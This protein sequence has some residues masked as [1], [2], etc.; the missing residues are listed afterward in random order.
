MTKS[1]GGDLA[2]FNNLV[3]ASMAFAAKVASQLV[4]SRAVEDVCQEAFLSAYLGLHRL[5][6]PEKYWG[7]LKAVVAKRSV[8]YW[9]S[10]RQHTGMGESDHTL[11]GY[12]GET[13]PER[14]QARDELRAILLRLSPEEVVLFKLALVEE[15]PYRS[16]AI[17]FDTTVLGIK[18]RVHKL[19]KKLR[20]LAVSC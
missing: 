10:A 12:C 2:A 9:R 20:S 5:R 16:I 15:T 11:L 18:L 4:P 17:A 7:W 6:E 14:V 8:D 13:S 3:I 19:K 1:Q